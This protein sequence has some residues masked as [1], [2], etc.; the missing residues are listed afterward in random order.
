MP[1]H[2]HVEAICKYQMLCLLVFVNLMQT[3]AI[4]EEEHSIEK[5]P[6]SEGKS[7]EAQV[8]EVGKTPMFLCF[9]IMVGIT[10]I[11]KLKP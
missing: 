10:K 5:M 9:M 2:A 7:V 3:W 8:T 4:W 11:T 1:L 6:L